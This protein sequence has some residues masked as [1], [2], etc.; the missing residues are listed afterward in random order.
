MK[1]LVDGGDESLSAIPW[2]TQTAGLQAGSLFL[3]RLSVGVL[4]RR[5]DQAPLGA[6][7]RLPF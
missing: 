2:N 3:N 6:T 1:P 4:A 5:N 7:F